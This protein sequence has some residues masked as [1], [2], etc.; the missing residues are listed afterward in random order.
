V[1]RSFQHQVEVARIRTELLRET[2][3]AGT[4]ATEARVE[5]AHGDLH[6]ACP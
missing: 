5:N 2:L 6:P 4:K 3:E 1:L